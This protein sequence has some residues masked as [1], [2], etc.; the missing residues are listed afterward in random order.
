VST[1]SFP[2]G[3]VLRASTTGFTVG[4]RVL[5]PNT[6]N[7]GYFVKVPVGETQVIGLIYNVSVNDD[8][9]VRQL[10]LAETLGPEAMRDQRENRLVPIEV[11]V[12]VV[13]YKLGELYLQNL[14][15][16]PPISLDELQ[17]CTRREVKGFT[18]SLDY[19]RLVL[20]AN[21]VPVDDLL[22]ASLNQARQARAEAEQRDFLLKAGR[23]IGRYL[24][25]DLVR[26]ESIIRQLRLLAPL[27]AE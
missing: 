16:Q 18:E 6:P 9:A 8:P 4:C 12:L 21:Q 1:Q 14:P 5:E 24:S 15:P 27:P 2:V 20:K 13:G 25:N 3:W 19:L 17:T 11:S 22:I 10:I 26:L 7:F 23:E